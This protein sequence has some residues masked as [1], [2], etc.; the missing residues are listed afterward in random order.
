MCVYQYI[1]FHCVHTLTAEGSEPFSRPDG[2]DWFKKGYN[3]RNNLIG[4]FVFNMVDVMVKHLRQQF[5]ME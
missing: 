5:K 3:T 1:D 2:C 4:E